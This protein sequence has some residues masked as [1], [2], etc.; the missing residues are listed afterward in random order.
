[1]TSTLRHGLVA[2]A[3][4]AGLTACGGGAT[5]TPAKPGQ[6]ACGV[7]PTPDPAATLPSGFPAPEQVLYQPVTQGSAHIVFG[8]VADGDFVAVRDDLVKRLTAKGYTIDST[9]QESV[10]AEAEF[11]G[12][13][14]G[15][16][17]VEP[18]CKGHVTV[19]YKILG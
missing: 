5:E 10:E 19:R 14:R 8:L 17:K 2:A 18:V 7:L 1:M 6:Q 11:S 4:L 15:T 12:P 16:V 9:D 3:L 13:H